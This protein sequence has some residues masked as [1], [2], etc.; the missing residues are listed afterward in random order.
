MRKGLIIL[1]ELEDD[2]L[3]W[4][5]RAG[6]IRALPAGHRLIA[7]GT[8]IDDLFFV[9]E[10]AFTVRLA[11]GHEVAELGPGDVIGEMSFVEKRPPG[12]DVTAAGPSRILSVPR[13]ALIAEF[14]RNHRF[15]ARF[16][17][18]LAVFLSDRLRSMGRNPDRELDE[19]L[20]DHLHLAGDRTL[21]LIGLLKGESPAA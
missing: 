2:D 18:A 5:S 6:T 4:L 13:S 9:I 17:R 21:R 14:G 16:Y 11:D 19:L 10:G 7:A 20:L 1:G 8:D 3:I 12:A 15:S